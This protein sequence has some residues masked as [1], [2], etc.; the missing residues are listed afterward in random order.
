MQSPRYRPNVAAIIRKN[1]GLILV[2]ERL[3]IPDSWQ[4]PQG[5]VKKSEP[6]AEALLR[7][8]KEEVSLEPRH[9]RVVDSKGPYR[10]LFDQGQT[11]EGYHGQEQTYFLVDLLASESQV[12]TATE[13]PE[14]RRIRWIRPEEFQ[15][16]WLPGFKQDVYRKV[17]LDFF[18]VKI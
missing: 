6:S 3:N 4:F 11:K 1:D 2:G 7:E 5:G 14:F 13:N 16:S 18:G 12:S 10:Y 9:Y 8:L 17:F 15:I